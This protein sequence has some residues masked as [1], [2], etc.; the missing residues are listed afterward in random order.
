MTIVA[1]LLARGV[2][3]TVL[4]LGIKEERSPEQ[5]SGWRDG[6]RQVPL[7]IREA[8]QLTRSNQTILLLLG[9]TFAAGLAI[10]SIE[11]FWQPFFAGLLGD[12]QENSFIFGL[13]M[14]GYFLVGIVGN[15]AATYLSKWLQKQYTLVAALFQGLEGIFLITLG[16]LTAV[17]PAAAVFWLAYMSLSGVNSPQA[18]MLNQAIPAERRS[19]MLS[20]QSLAGF[21]GSIVG[22]AGLGFVAE[23]FSIQAAWT[24]A[25]VV[26]LVSLLLYVPIHLQKRHE[27][28]T[29]ILPT[30]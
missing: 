1:S 4:I 22:S 27:Q 23:H 9:T 15:L 11:I 19:A 26:L 3:F 14:T 10:I 29:A 24:I 16:S 20:V 5:M 13:L 18:A 30:S 28:K 17:I 12:G 25:G 7:I 21:A 8:V 6:V 2:L